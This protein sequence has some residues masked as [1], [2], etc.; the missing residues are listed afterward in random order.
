VTH[1]E[2]GL[3][4]IQYVAATGLSLVIFVILANVVVDLYARGAVR[5]AVDE[6]AR[7]GAPIDTS[8]DACE[9]R[10]SDVLD[11]LLGGQMRAGVQ[12]ECTDGVDTVRAHAHVVLPSWFPAVIPDWTF[13]ITGSAVKE[14]E[15]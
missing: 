7:A 5:A 10:A 8:I 1:R 4:T 11:H 9:R 3:S 13:S 6:A 14:R 12:V 15:P 2:A